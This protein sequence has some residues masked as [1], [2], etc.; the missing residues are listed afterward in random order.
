MGDFNSE[1]NR[2]NRFDKL[3]GKFIKKLKM[4]D[5]TSSDE[6]D[7]MYKKVNYTAKIDHIF[8]RSQK[9]SEI[10][11]KIIKDILDTSD[12][13]PVQAIIKFKSKENP[14][15]SKHLSRR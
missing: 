14:I 1:L 8:T 3:L 5:I 7:C 11:G 2:D 13:R 15:A 10:C 4:C 12:R 6:S 9:D